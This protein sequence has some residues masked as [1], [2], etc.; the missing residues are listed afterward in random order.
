VNAYDIIWGFVN[1]NVSARTSQLVNV[2]YDMCCLLAVIS[3]NIL[4]CKTNICVISYIRIS[5]TGVPH[6][7]SMP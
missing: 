1:K 5:K 6:L 2:E 7:V 3:M 4:G